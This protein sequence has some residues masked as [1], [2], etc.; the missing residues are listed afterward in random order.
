MWSRYICYVG[1][2]L[3]LCTNCDQNCPEH[4]FLSFSAFFTVLIMIMLRIDKKV[5]MLK[6]CCRPV[7]VI[8]EGKKPHTSVEVK[9]WKIQTFLS[10]N[11]TQILSAILSLKVHFNHQS[12][13]LNWFEFHYIFRQLTKVSPILWWPDKFFSKILKWKCV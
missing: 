6:L 4:A 5:R 1:L 10:L 9:S 2:E 3:F 7:K 11:V 13:S 12:N 8:C